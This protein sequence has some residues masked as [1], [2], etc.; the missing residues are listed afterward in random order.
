MKRNLKV[1]MVIVII[2]FSGTFIT[3]FTSRQVT[4]K[5]TAA[6]A[7]APAREAVRDEA[8]GTEVFAVRGRAAGAPAAAAPAAGAPAPA[9]ADDQPET[10]SAELDRAQLL[11]EY[12]TRLEETDA[13]IGQMRSKETDHSAAAMKSLAQTE[14]KIWEK[15][16]EY[17][18]SLLLVVLTEDEA[19]QLLNDHEA[20]T[21]QR[22]K[23]AQEAAKKNSGGSRESLEYTAAIA[24][25]TRARIYHLLAVYGQE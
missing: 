11:A 4:A 14:Q 2:I 13:R 9:A 19:R 3:F 25:A 8:D 21:A 18:N 5:R 15:E 22:D 6:I 1:W 12:Q 7:L 10:G 20:W 24:A 16:L 23:K 17:V